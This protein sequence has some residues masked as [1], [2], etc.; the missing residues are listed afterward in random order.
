MINEAVYTLYEGVGSVEAIDTA[1][2]LG[3]NHPMGPLELADFIGLD[4]CL[5]IMQVL[6]EGLADCKYRPCP[7]LVKYVEAGW[8]GRK[9]QSRILRLRGR[10]RRDRRGKRPNHRSACSASSR[11]PALAATTLSRRPATLAGPC[12]VR[13]ASAVNPTM[14]RRV[15]ST[16]FGSHRTLR[17]VRWR[18]LPAPTNSPNTGRSAT[19]PRRRSRAATAVARPTARFVIQKHAATRL[20]Y[21]FRLELDG[22]FK[23]WAVTRGP[24]ARSAGQAARGRSRGPSARLWRLRGHDPE[25][26]VWRRHRACSGIAATGSRRADPQEALA[27]GRSQ[28]RARRR[29]A[30][31]QLGAGP[32]EAGPARRQ[33]QQLAADQASR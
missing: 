19:S 13:A 11:P 6:S 26:R 17:A 4:T 18:D 7:L 24:V 30:A 29:A 9:A 3:A 25:G 14:V 21:D 22:V 8:L 16:T 32:H 12:S 23:C 1:M 28:I 5:S 15:V 20:H 31:G 10:R 2:K 33:A 27:Q